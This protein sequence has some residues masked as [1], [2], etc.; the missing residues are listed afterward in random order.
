MKRY[1]IEQYYTPEEKCVIKWVAGL[2]DGEK[3]LK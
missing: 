2:E 1:S 3:A